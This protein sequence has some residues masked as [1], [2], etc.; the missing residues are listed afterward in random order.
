MD[1]EI[2]G[3]AAA[4]L[5]TFASAPQLV[6]II[7]SCET[8]AVSAVSYTILLLGL[9]LWTVYGCLKWDWP[10]IASNALAA[11]ICAMVLILKMLPERQLKALHDFFIR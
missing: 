10:V 9:L 11:V 4:L 6:K 1:P 5:T 8:K 2:I 3:Y 7:Q